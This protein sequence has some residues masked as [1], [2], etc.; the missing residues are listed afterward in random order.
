MTEPRADEIHLAS[1]TVTK[2]NIISGTMDLGDPGPMIVRQMAR[3]EYKL[4]PDAVI[5]LDEYG[6]NRFS[7]SL[8]ILSKHYTKSIE[9]AIPIGLAFDDNYMAPY[10]E[11]LL[12]DAYATIGNCAH[13]KIQP[14]PCFSSVP[15]PDCGELVKI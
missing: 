4:P 12:Q 7:L 10:L 3:P 11:Q 2:E 5:T 14:N 13:L 15:C 6:H 9:F 8:D 1:F